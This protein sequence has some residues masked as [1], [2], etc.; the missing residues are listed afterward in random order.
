MIAVAIM[1]VIVHKFQLISESFAN[2]NNEAIWTCTTFF[3]FEKKDRWAAFENCMN[4]IQSVNSPEELKRISKWLVVNEHSDKPKQD[5]A[6]MMREKYPFVEFIQKTKDQHGQAKGLNMIMERISPYKY[7][8]HWE[9]T[10]DTRA[11]FINR[12]IREMDT[13][14]DISQ[15]QLT[16]DNGRP[17]WSDVGEARMRCEG[18]LCRIAPHPETP[19]FINN[20]TKDAPTLQTISSSGYWPLYSLR[21]SINRV[22]FYTS[23]GIG[24][25]PEEAN[26]WPYLFELHY[27]IRWL[28]AGAV[29]AIFTDPPVIRQHNHTS[30]Y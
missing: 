27:S 3:D 8:F 13:N 14:N 30:T 17:D 16:F 21:P 12:C 9:E 19:S 15:I 29:K 22:S 2:P 11:P 20:N 6:A 10:W 7:W 28:R 5:W 23:K 25:F 24:N 4:T 18:T 1:F 26:L